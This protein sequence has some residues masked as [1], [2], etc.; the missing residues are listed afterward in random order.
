[1]FRKVLVANR[2]EIALRVMRTCRELGIE[3]IAIYSPVD[4]SSHHR[5]YAD[6]AHEVP[7]EDPLRSYL[8]IEAIV[9][10]AQEA[11]AEAIHP[12]YGFLSENPAFVR[13]CDEAGIVFV[14]PP[15]A[16]MEVTGDKLR[17]KAV[18]REAGVPLS[19][20]SDSPLES[21]EEAEEAAEAVGYPV[22]LKVAGGG[23]GIG[24]E[25]VREAMDLA[26]ALERAQ[27]LALSAF[28]VS[29]IFLERYHR[30]ARHIEFQILS[31][32]KRTIHLGERECSIQRRYQK[33]VE[34][35]PSPVVD[36]ELRDEI[37]ALSTR[38]AEALGYANAGTIEYIYSGGNFYF[39][40]VNARLQVEH[41]VTEWL[42]GLDLV[43]EQ[44]ALAAGDPLSLEQEDV[45]LRG[46]ALE[47]RINA[48]NPYRSFLPSPGRVTHLGLPSGPGVRVDTA[49]QVGTEVTTAY[50]PLVAKII[51]YGRDRQQTTRRMSRALGETL[52][53]G[54]TTNIPF[55]EA[56]LRDEAFQAGQL[57]IR[58]IQERRIIQALEGARM[59]EERERRTLVAALAAAAVASE[60]TI[61][62]RMEAF[63]IRPRSPKAWTRAGR[64][65]QH[66][67]RNHDVAVRR[68]L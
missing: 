12:G 10:V 55:H 63:P 15:A 3:T 44:L 46:W 53:Q 7:S 1:M 24:M 14:G 9:G 35:A 18:L 26:P 47:C 31:D 33:L 56:V 37:G 30:H 66:R 65:E 64:E 51:A 29:D 38:A 68:G 32:G 45:V 5:F 16:A 27:S 4:A 13:A 11:E 41:P 62:R 19:P 22:L 59:K 36:A 2:G 39:N 8:D 43:A 34:E 6:E 23:G 67:G 49:L 28:D 52:I 48:E 21:P 42:T 54:I 57:S 50:D 60:G 61:P 25:L 17:S 20:G 40:E 58:F